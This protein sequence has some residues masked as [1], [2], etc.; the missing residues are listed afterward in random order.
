MTQNIKRDMEQTKITESEREQQRIKNE[1]GI[2]TTQKETTNTTQ[3]KQET[4]RDK[5]KPQRAKQ[6]NKTWKT[7]R[8]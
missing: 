5:Q 7:K 1:K 4:T 2:R 6:Q 8:T 3:A